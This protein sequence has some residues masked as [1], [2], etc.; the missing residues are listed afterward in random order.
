LRKSQH[1]PRIAFFNISLG[2]LREL[3]GLS[4]GEHGGS[5]RIR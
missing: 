2:E 5:F 4:R 3:E 1:R